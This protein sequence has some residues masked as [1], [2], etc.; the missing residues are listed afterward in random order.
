VLDRIKKARQGELVV[1]F[2]TVRQAVHMMCDLGVRSKAVYED[3]LE[4]PLLRATEEFFSGASSICI[5][6]STTPQY[7]LWVEAQYV[8]EMDRCK[9]YLDPSAEQKIVQILDDKLVV[10]H[11]STLLHMRQSDLDSLLHDEARLTDLARM[12]T[13]FSR[14][15]QCLE[16]LNV[17]FGMCV[18][19]HGN[20]IVSR[21]ASHDAVASAIQLCEELFAAKDLFENVVKKCFKNDKSMQKTLKK[22]FESFINNNST[23]ASALAMYSDEKLK[24]MV[25]MR[26]DSQL[27]Q[28]LDNVIG[29]FRMLSDKDVFESYY[30]NHLSRRLLSGKAYSEDAERAMLSKLKTECGSQFTSKMEA[31]F[32][33]IRLSQETMDAYRGA[34]AAAAAAAAGSTGADAG[35]ECIATVLT[36]GCWPSFALGQQ[37]VPLPLPLQAWKTSFESHY[38]GKHSGRRLTWALAMGSCDVKGS[39]FKS[40]MVHEFTVTLF[41]ACALLVLSGGASKSLQE[42]SMHLNLPMDE[43]K[44]QLVSLCVGKFN[45]L[46]KS[47]TLKELKSTDVYAANAEFSSKL[48]RVRIPLVSATSKGL[49][50]QG[51]TASSAVADLPSDVLEDRKHLID[52]AIVRVMKSR[53]RLDH[54]SLV[55]EVARQMSARFNP[56][57]QDV[58][59]RIESLIERE[60][61]ERD[62]TDGRVYVYMA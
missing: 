13:I 39:G 10:Q 49:G 55:A 25:A 52:A 32:N 9:R 58:K 38:L 27:D 40:D 1:D 8:E 29:L 2:D 34:T 23:C 21:Q 35:V 16:E 43:C 30:K 47:G 54:A 48:R 7:L 3:E 28:L 12:Y 36:S 37:D 44:R 17:A 33:D 56:S 41:Q 60:Y 45:V 62:A 11:C 42:V 14:S 19:E 20:A 18:I 5:A 24:S 53:K 59:K 15:A 51:G 31:M 4:T 46:V 6:Y 57:P 22:S 26:D 61:V 50:L